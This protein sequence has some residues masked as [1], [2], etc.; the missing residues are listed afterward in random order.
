MVIH[1]VINYIHITNQCRK[2]REIQNHA[3]AVQIWLFLKLNMNH[4]K[5]HSIYK[6][7]FNV[8]MGYFEFKKVQLILGVLQIRILCRNPKNRSKT[9]KSQLT[10]Y[11]NLKTYE[12]AKKS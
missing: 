8:K 6:L 12:I 10:Y 7:D 9:S 4:Y 1:D 3:A 2:R 11:T 5:S